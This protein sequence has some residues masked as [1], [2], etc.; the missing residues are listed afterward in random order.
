MRVAS[1]STKVWD[2]HHHKASVIAN[3]AEA[4]ARHDPG[5][6]STQS[7]ASGADHPQLLDVRSSR[8]NKNPYTS[9]SARQSGGAQDQTRFVLT[10]VMR[11][12]SITS[13]WAWARASTRPWAVTPQPRPQLHPPVE[14]AP[15]SGPGVR[16]HSLSGPPCGS[17][18]CCHQAAVG[19]VAVTWMT[20][21]STDDPLTGKTMSATVDLNEIHRD[22]GYLGVYHYP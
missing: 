8:G 4:P 7:H 2:Y 5:A 6:A 3:E 21:G 17:V 13:P 18:S 14:A 20:R 9:S 16:P 10:S 15:N 1:P 11:A 12:A 19:A 22:G